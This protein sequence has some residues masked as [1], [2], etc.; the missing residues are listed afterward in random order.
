MSTSLVT[1][2]SGRRG[3]RVTLHDIC[4]YTH[5][6]VPAYS[7]GTSNTWT[8]K[9]HYC[10]GI[11]MGYQWQCVEFARRWLW[12]THRLLLPERN[13]AYCFSSCTYVYR[14]KEDPS[15]A[16]QQPRV[17]APTA[18]SEA[19][20][21][22]PLPSTEVKTSTGV[23]HFGPRENKNAWEKV[24]A[25]FVRQGSRVPPAAESL[26]VYPMSFGSPWGHIGVITAVDLNQNLVCVADQN[27]YFHDWNGKPY[28][29]IFQLECNKGRFYI[30]DHESECTGWLTF[31]TVV[32]GH[33]LGRVTASR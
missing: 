15:P 13:C 11:F 2:S 1:V 28:S 5:Q 12:T 14:L 7:N 23:M 22:S 27:R 21:G 32:E 25:K 6:G 19:S 4:G 18:A 17:E 9:K 24:P 10:E 30:R 29:A 33:Q 8:N 31:P 20:A 26:I 16:L 3:G